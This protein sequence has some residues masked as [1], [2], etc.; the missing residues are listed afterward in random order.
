MRDASRFDV[1]AAVHFAH[2]QLAESCRVKQR[3]SRALLLRLAEFA[4]LTIESLSR[5]H[6]VYLFGNGGSAADAQ[7]IAAELQGRLRL[8]RPGLRAQA[9]TTNTSVLTA[10]GNDYG[11]T[12]IFSRQVESLVG[13]SDIVVGITTSGASTNVLKGLRAARRCGAE[14]GRAHV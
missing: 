7:H 11:Y 5:G 14:I 6:C 10:V 4:Q 3:I 13:G 12:D 2:R 8:E 9:L 1:N